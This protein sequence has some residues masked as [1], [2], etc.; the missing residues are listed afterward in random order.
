MMLAVK[1]ILKYT[2]LTLVFIV[3]ASLATFAQ[4]N[5]GKNPPPKVDRPLVPVKPKETP[6][7]TPTPTEK[8]KKPVAEIAGNMQSITLFI[9]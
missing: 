7:P 4:S 6:T 1:K 5:D 8:P 2:L 3:G 9:A